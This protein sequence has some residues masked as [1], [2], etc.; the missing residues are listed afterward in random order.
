MK[1]F[2]FLINLAFRLFYKNITPITNNDQDKF[3]ELVDKYVSEQEGFENNWGYILQATRAVG[4]K[5]SL[6]NSI[7]YFWFRKPTELVI[8]NLLGPEKYKILTVLKKYCHFLPIK[9]LVKNVLE[10]DIPEYKSLGFN[11]KKNPWSQY[12]FM[13]DNTFPQ[14]TS[15]A[16]G[17]I[18]LESE[19]LRK[20]YKYSIKKFLKNREIKIYEYQPED[21]KIILQILKSNAKY[22]EKKGVEKAKEVYKAHIF[23]FDDAIKYAQRLVFIENKKIIGAAF[24]TV[25]NKIIYWNALINYAE[26]NIMNYLIWLSLVNIN[27]KQP[28]EKLSLQGCENFGQYNWKMGYYPLSTTK[29]VHMEF[30]TGA[31]SKE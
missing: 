12:S 17:I 16:A 27:K 18:N 13:D 8:V 9:I 29:K 28:L 26:S 25:K 7:A 14:I 6:E 11:V 23:F 15:N 1:I 5:L 3:Y 10:K 22:L 24:F 30:P 21:K 31:S 19:H 2:T 4:L 20:T